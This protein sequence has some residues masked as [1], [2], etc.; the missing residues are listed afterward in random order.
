MEAPDGTSAVNIR[1]LLSVNSTST[2]G[3]PR[4]SNISR[5]CKLA[6]VVALRVDDLAVALVRRQRRAATAAVEDLK[7]VE[8][9]AIVI[10]VL[11]L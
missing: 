1:P 2:V 7:I 11:V 9:M 4:L 6:M 8:S 5:A 3:F 10:F